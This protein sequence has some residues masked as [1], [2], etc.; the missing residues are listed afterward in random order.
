MTKKKKKRKKKRSNGNDSIFEYLRFSR[1]HR[2]RITGESTITDLR[3][4]TMNLQL[5]ACA[6]ITGR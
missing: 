5:I 2:V 4:S 3:G 6:T 1:S